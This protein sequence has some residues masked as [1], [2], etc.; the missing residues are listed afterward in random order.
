[1]NYRCIVTGHTPQ[2]RSYCAEDS[3]VKEAPGWMFNFWSSART[4][5]DNDQEVAFPISDARLSPLPGGTIFR[6]FQILPDRAFE[7]YSSADLQRIAAEIGLP[8]SAPEP[9]EKLWHRTNTLD[10]VLI[11]QGEPILH[12]EEGNVALKP[13]DTVIQRG[14]HHAWSNPGESVAIAACVLIDALPVTT[15]VRKS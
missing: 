8:E 5:A 6:F 12:L 9:G 7:T 3:L 10:Y 15:A 13:F 1:M 11:L 2:G 4:P 14:T